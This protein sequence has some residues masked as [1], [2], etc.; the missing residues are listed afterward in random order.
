VSDL[1][2]RQAVIDDAS[3]INVIY[4]GFI[5]DSH[6]SFDTEPWTDEQRRKWLT[7]SAE[8]GYPVLVAADRVGVVGAS[9]AGP[10]RDKDAYR[11]SVETTIVLIPGSEGSG[12]GTTLYRALLADLGARSFHR[13]YALIAL[14]NDPSIGLHR[15][16]GFADVGVLDDVGHKDGIYHSTMLMELKLETV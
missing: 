9:W 13:A 1:T 12:L 2:I 3:D 6:V 11:S 7:R 5:V 14:P 8:S 15:K 16:L 10:W 4:N